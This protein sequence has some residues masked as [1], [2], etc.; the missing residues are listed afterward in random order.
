MW[1]REFNRNGSYLQELQ[2]WEAEHGDTWRRLVVQWDKEE[3]NRRTLEKLMFFTGAFAAIGTVLTPGVAPAGALPTPRSFG[4]QGILA[5]QLK[6]HGNSLASPRPTWFYK[7]YN[8]DGTFL[9]NGITSQP[10]PELRYTKSFMFDKHFRNTQLFPNRRTAYDFEFQQNLI[11][12]GPLN[13]N[14]H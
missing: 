7:L 12:R 8:N 11:Q 14:M 5:P 4:F 1:L 2:N 10:L 13:L 9:K 6:I 3:L